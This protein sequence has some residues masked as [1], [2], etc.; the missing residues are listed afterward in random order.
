MVL[1]VSW[2]ETTSHPHLLASFLLLYQ[3]AHLTMSL[4]V[5]PTIFTVPTARSVSAIHQAAKRVVQVFVGNP[6]DALVIL[7]F[8]HSLPIVVLVASWR[9]AQNRK[10]AVTQLKP[11]LF[12]VNRRRIALAIL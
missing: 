8:G 4:P 11:S 2:R 1:L 3:P 5:S 12:C 10:P 7:A 6:V 9:I